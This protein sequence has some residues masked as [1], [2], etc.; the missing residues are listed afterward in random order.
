MAGPSRQRKRHPGGIRKTVPSGHIHSN[1]LAQGCPTLLMA[2]DFPVKFSS[3][4]TQTHL[5][6]LMNVFRIA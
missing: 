5:N 4:P 6:Q 2:I 3:N 1:S